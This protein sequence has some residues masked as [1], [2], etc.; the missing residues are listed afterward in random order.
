MSGF[1]YSAKTN[2]AY[3]QNDIEIFKAT[4]TWPDDAVLM[5]VEVFSEFFSE[6][7]PAGKIRI[8]GPDGLP[9]WADIPKPSKAELISQAEQQKQRRI[10]DAMQSISVIQL[11]LRAGRKLTPDETINLNLTLDYIEAVEA[12][13]TSTAPDINWPAI[14]A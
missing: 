9:A 5:S 12:T 10:D 4:G 1:Y 2:G 11:K 13:D 14:P 7:P 3:P 8:A 6:L